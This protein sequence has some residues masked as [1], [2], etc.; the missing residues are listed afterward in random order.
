MSMVMMMMKVMDVEPQ[1]ILHHRQA[2]N[3]LDSMSWDDVTFLLL[4]V[5][6]EKE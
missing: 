4:I 6:L 2:E 1:A 5:G 3:S